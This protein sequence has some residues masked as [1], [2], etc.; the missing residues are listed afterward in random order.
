MPTPLIHSM[1]SFTA[2]SHSQHGFWSM[3]GHIV[4]LFVFMVAGAR[5]VLKI[6]D[7]E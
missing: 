3:L 5:I 4:N 2:C 1:L 7:A 6:G